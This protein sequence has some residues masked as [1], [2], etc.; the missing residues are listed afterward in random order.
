MK[1]IKSFLLEVFNFY[2]IGLLF[3]VPAFLGYFFGVFLCLL[4]M[5]ID[6]SLSSCGS[7]NVC[8]CFISPPKTSIAFFAL[9]NSSWACEPFVAINKPYFLHSGRHNSLTADISDH[10]V[11][12][13]V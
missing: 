7:E 9:V 1:C 11:A 10:A 2:S 13:T 5:I 12:R 3:G 6:R 8:V 4:I